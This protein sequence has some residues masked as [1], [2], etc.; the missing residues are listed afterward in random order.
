[1]DPLR[2]VEV[3]ELLIKAKRYS[4]VDLS[5]KGTTKFS[6]DGASFN[7]L[8][9]EYAKRVGAP[10]ELG[11]GSLILLVRTAKESFALVMA[12]TKSGEFRA[13]QLQR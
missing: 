12:R 13:T 1:M 5:Y 4:R 6:I 8:G 11:E 9:E 10:V 2:G 7:R 3:A